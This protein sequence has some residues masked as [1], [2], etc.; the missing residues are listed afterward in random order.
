MNITYII[1]IA[2]LYLIFLGVTDFVTDLYIVG[3]P[4]KYKS[5]S[6]TVNILCFMIIWIFCPLFICYWIGYASCAI[7]SR[8]YRKWKE[9]NPVKE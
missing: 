5:I 6:T 1:L 2:V 9:L 3:N 4:K 8:K 7:L